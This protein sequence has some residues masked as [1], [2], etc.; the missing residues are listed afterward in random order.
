MLDEISKQLFLKETGWD[1]AA[2]TLVGED[3]SQRRITRLTKAHETAILM[4]SVPDDQPQLTMGHKSADYVRV[5]K[6]LLD[7]G[8]S[9]PRIYA[10]NVPRGLML[11][12]DF[13]TKSY[14]EL[15]AG[16]DT[17]ALALYLAATDVL[18]HLY[19]NTADHQIALPE[20]YKGYVHTGRRRVIDWYTPALRRTRNED[21]LVE[22]YLEV[23]KNIESRLPPV[24]LRFQHV[25]FHPYNLMPLPDRA[26]A[27]SVG[28]ID[29]QDA[30][31]GPAPY[32]LAN[33]LLDA[34][35]IVPEDI[36][37][38]CLDKF[39]QGLPAA[40]WET[41]YA[42]Y[43]VLACQ[44]H[45]RIIGQAFRLAVR[46]SKTRLLAYVPVLQQHMLRDLAEPELAPLADFFRQNGISFSDA[47]NPDIAGLAAFIRDDAF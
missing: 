30:M 18:I 20:Y 26:G 21:G 38:A 16:P 44:F 25:D 40:E 15:L 9:A 36:R 47:L 45:C 24:P 34:R 35:R 11:V 27:A 23:W 10:A 37:N 14:H 41:F 19:K 32:D 7:L 12:E 8:L 2:E 33:L 5:D 22:T 46:D 17:N 1:Q 39:K 42:W 28:L 43:K 6:Y 31:L 4:H 3:W 13:G 29:F